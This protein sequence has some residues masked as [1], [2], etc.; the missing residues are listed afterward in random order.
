MTH[1]NEFNGEIK[2]LKRERH[3]KTVAALSECPVNTKSPNV[4][5]EKSVGVVA[6]KNTHH[7]SKYF[8]VDKYFTSRDLATLKRSANKSSHPYIFNV[9]I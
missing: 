4:N 2:V 9:R 6:Q 1:G 8:L 5:S 7:A 3:V